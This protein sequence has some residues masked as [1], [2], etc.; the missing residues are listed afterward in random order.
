MM[1]QE[2]DKDIELDKMDDT[3]GDENPHRQLIVN[4]AGKIET[5]ICDGAMVNT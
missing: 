4:K 5:T 2:I 1:R 3:R